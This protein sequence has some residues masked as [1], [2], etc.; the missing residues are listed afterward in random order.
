[1]I[2]WPR[3]EMHS[4]LDIFV[5]RRMQELNVPSVS[6]AIVAGGRIA[7]LG[8]Y[9]F[10]DKARGLRVA[11]DTVFQA[12]ELGESVA[13]YAAMTMLRDK[14]LFL[15]A[16]LSHDID[17]RWLEDGDDDARVTLR[18]VLTHTSGLPDNTVH[19]SRET[20]F[21]PG[22]D[23]SPSG[24]GFLYLQ[25]V[26]SVLDRKPFEQS[27]QTRVFTP[28]GMQD[29]TFLRNERD[30]SRSAR[31][32]VP[33]GFPLALFF[34]PSMSVFLLGMLLTMLILRFAGDGRLLQPSDMV[35]PA[36][37]GTATSI[38]TVGIVLGLAPM[39]LSVLIAALYALI[40][41]SLA[42]LLFWVGGKLGIGRP[43]DGVLLRGR[44]NGQRSLL[45]GSILSTFLVS[46]FFFG[47]NLPVPVL[48]FG[49]QPIPNAAASF[50][51]NAQDMARFMLE[52]IN[53]SELGQSTHARML[54]ERV[55]IDGRRGWT[56]ALGV[57]RESNGE[58]LWSRG[59]VTG[60][61]SLMVIDPERQVGVVILTNARQGAELTQEVARNIL[62]LDGV[63]TQP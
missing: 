6:I 50:R 29:S 52:L 9:G 43:R 33:L 10:A 21:T 34:I 7:F 12:G 40:V 28:L 15:D 51:T 60:F 46:F 38:I 8:S 49:E 57:R 23:F 36:I 37:I 61:E 30:W 22:S 11:P 63:W 20:R 45:L 4:A 24:V 55:K 19:P 17:T 54:G 62:G 14:L 32:Y 59:A 16:P 26:M 39:L 27:M 35:L 13:A 58:T 41:G 25:H 2:N 53:G 31:G 48:P 1:M 47:R 44:S 42:A 3:H 5:P 18:H 56:L